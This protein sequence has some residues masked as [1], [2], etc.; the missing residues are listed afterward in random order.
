MEWDDRLGEEEDMIRM[1]R[2]VSVDQDSVFWSE[3]TAGYDLSFD[4]RILSYSYFPLILRL[5]PA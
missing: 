5:M 3:M 2:I 1:L 4:S